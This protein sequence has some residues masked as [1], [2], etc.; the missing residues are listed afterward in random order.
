MRPQLTVFIIEVS[1]FRVSTIAG[2][3][4][5]VTISEIDMY[6]YM[7]IHIIYILY[8]CISTSTSTRAYVHV[9]AWYSHILVN[10]YIK[11]L[12]M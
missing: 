8:R 6:V 10:S 5:T 3:T 2:L 12:H 7:Y 11:C 4:V 1:F 9:H